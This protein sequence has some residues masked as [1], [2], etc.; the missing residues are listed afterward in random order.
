M[1]YKE[2]KNIFVALCFFLGLQNWIPLNPE[3][4]G[5]GTLVQYIIHTFQ[6][7]LNSNAH[8]RLNSGGS[9]T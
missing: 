5:G 4:S 7:N 9:R 2:Q 3:P 6:R 8:I 1:Q